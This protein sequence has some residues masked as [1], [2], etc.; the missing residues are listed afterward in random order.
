LVDQKFKY[1]PMFPKEDED[2]IDARMLL[3]M[4]ISINFHFISMFALIL[5]VPVSKNHKM[6]QIS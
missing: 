2:D 3:K 4:I 5:Y 1:L 6:F